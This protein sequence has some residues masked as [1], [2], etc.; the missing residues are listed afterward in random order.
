MLM[1]SG[2]RA[3]KLG[4]ILLNYGF[5]TETELKLALEE[6]SRTGE[7]LGE[8]LIRLG[9]VTEEEVSFAIAHQAGVEFVN[10]EEVIINP[11]VLKLVPY[12]VARENKVVPIETDGKSITIAIQDPFNFKAIDTIEQITGLRVVVKVAR[13]EQILKAIENLYGL[14]VSSD[15]DLEANIREAIRIQQLGAEVAP[16]ANI[17]NLIVLKGIQLDAT[18]I[19]IEPSD[20][21][22][23]IRYRVDGVLHPIYTIPRRLHPSIVTRI[24][25]MS[26]L[27]IGEQRIP[28]DGGF[29]FQLGMKN[30]N[31]RVSTYPTPYGESVV[32]RILERTN[33]ILG[34]EKL[35]L[36]E[37]KLA[38]IRN[39]IRKPF[40]II[41]VCGP[42]GSGKTT[43]LNSILLE[44]NS[45]EKNIM[46]IE[47][48]IEYRLP[49]IKQSQVNEKAGFTFANALRS[50]L[51]HDPDVILVGEM[52]DRETAELAFQASLTGHLVLTT[53]HANTAIQAIPRLLNLGVDP[54]IMSIGLIA[55]IGQRLVRR[56]CENCKVKRPVDI[57]LI[58]KFGLE[59]YFRLDEMEFAG[60][61]CSNCFHTAYRGRT[62]I[63]EILEITE[64]VRELIQRGASLHEI[65][66]VV[67]YETMLED[68]IRKVKKGIT[69]L[70]EVLRVIG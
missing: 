59:K 44:L 46:T 58:K 25:I 43:T 34:L 53:I 5:I 20:K 28:Q 38:R 55:I 37:E 17:V 45:L 31:I 42:T 50:I 41:I 48:P 12:K 57:D 1:D 69:N 11:A 13:E 19:H 18:D 30:I 64:E 49:L 52:R 60:K 22:S 29:N 9:L 8:I 7:K 15:E 40:G 24:K 70:S 36:S 35:G 66:S 67:K 32:L 39:L 63:F 14:H 27:D 68:G 16:I 65:E 26:N 23:R 62:G 54:Y 33:I 61:G 21:V 4:E 47:D 10:L 3:L 6:Q 2:K 56:V 51:R